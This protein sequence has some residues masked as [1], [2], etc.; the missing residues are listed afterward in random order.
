LRVGRVITVFVVL[1]AVLA[2]LVLTLINLRWGLSIAAGIAVGVVS[3]IGYARLSAARQFLTPGE[4]LLQAHLFAIALLLAVIAA[5]GFFI[6]A[7]LTGSNENASGSLPATGD[8]ALDVREDQ[9]VTMSDDDGHW[10]VDSTITIDADV[11]KPLSLYDNQTLV[12]SYVASVGQTPTKSDADFAAIIGVFTSGLAAGGWEET[13]THEVS[14]YTFVRHSTVDVPPTSLRTPTVVDHYTTAELPSVGGL[15]LQPS[16]EST[17][18]FDVDC[19][20][21]PIV[22]PQVDPSECSGG[23]QRFAIKR[24]SLVGSADQAVDLT[25]LWLPLPNK[26]GVFVGQF[27]AFRAFLAVLVAIIAALLTFMK[28]EAIDRGERQLRGVL[29]RRAQPAGPTRQ[30]PRPTAHYRLSEPT[31]PT[32]RR[33]RRRPYR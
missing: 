10:Q 23:R 11:V 8:P 13:A 15:A 27:T 30:R 31:S 14:S 19:D 21:I 29:D 26:A 12:E 24:S 9:T 18:N 2:A 28:K 5:A 3:A 7:R 20:R 16:S 25:V 4:R 6:G 33:T 17:L 1:G 32:T 22:E